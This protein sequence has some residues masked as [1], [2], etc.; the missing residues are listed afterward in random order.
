MGN[1]G[2]LPFFDGAAQVD[3]QQGAVFLNHHGVVVAQPA[4]G[5]AHAGGAAALKKP[6]QGGGEQGISVGKVTGEL[7][8]LPLHGQPGLQ[9]GVGPHAGGVH[10]GDDGIPLGL[11]AVDGP[12]QRGALRGQDAAG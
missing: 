10:G 12:L 7:G 1:G 5:A 3:V 6:G 8:H 9:T 11:C 2:Q 4:Q